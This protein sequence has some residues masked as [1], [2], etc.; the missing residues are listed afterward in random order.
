MGSHQQ[1]QQSDE[2]IQFLLTRWSSAGR[3]VEEMIN[4]TRVPSR[5]R[6]ATPSAISYFPSSYCSWMELLR[7][8]HQCQNLE[9][10]K[11]IV[12]DNPGMYEVRYQMQ[13]N[14]D[15]PYYEWVHIGL[16]GI[17][18]E[19]RLTSRIQ[20]LLLYTHSHRCPILDY[21]AEELKLTGSQDKRD[22]KAKQRLEVRWSSCEQKDVE[23]LEYLF[24]LL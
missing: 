12:P 5:C 1:K 17:S 19:Q 24:H 7:L 6:T 2:E 20:N 3:M 21:V 10:F 4:L 22:A 16:A 11:S 15:V 23:R 18:K 9:E 14:G 8:R 13:L